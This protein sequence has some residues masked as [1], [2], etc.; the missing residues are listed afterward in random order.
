MA[1][2]NSAAS[3]IP[4]IISVRMSAQRREYFRSLTLNPMSTTTSAATSAPVT[5][6]RVTANT[7]RMEVLGRAYISQTVSK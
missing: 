2:P 7:L 6:P 5:N 1:P 3:I 4:T